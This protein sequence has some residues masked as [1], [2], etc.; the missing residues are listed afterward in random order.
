MTAHYAGDAN[1]TASDGAAVAIVINKARA[2]ITVTAFSVT[3]NG[4]AHTATGT[5]TGVGGVDLAAGLNLSGTTHTNAGTYNGDAWSFHDASG[6]YLDD[7]GTVD[8][9]I[10]RATA[11][12]TVTALQ[13]HLRRQPHTATGT[14]TGVGGVSFSGGLTLSGTT[15]TDAGTYNGDAWSFAGGT[16]Y[17]DANGTVND[18]IAK[19]PSTTT[20]TIRGGPFVWTGGPLTPAT[21]YGDGRWR[22]EPDAHSELCEQRQRRPGHRQLLLCG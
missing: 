5:A 20:V 15:H 13:R 6:N 22:P 7:S 19:A 1:H 9:S 11:S 4:Q 8:D 2:S 3:F 17:F 10:A 14:A 18:S 12:I 16:N 21:G